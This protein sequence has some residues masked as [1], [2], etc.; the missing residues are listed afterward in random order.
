MTL[1]GSGM[2]PV[3]PLGELLPVA[4]SVVIRTMPNRIE[5]KTK[6]PNSMASRSFIAQDWPAAGRCVKAGAA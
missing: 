6:T 4:D 5:P 1:A 2:P 3:T